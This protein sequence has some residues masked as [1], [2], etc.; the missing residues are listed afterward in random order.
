MTGTVAHGSVI[1]ITD[2]AARFGSRVNVK[3]LYVSLGNQKAGSPLGRRTDDYYNAGTEASAAHPVGALTQAY[4]YDFKGTET[5]NDVWGGELFFTENATNPLLQYVERYYDFDVYQA[6]YQGDFGFNLKT[7]RIWGD[8]R[9]SS[10]VCN[11]YVG[12]NGTWPAGETGA[13]NAEYTNDSA[14][15]MNTTVAAFQWL[16]EEYL[17]KNAS[18][19]NV[20]DGILEF[21]RD[22][23]LQNAAKTNFIT[24][25][26]ANPLPLTM[27]FLDQVSNGSGNGV[28][29]VY[30]YLGYMNFDDE[31]RRVYLSNSAT[32]APGSKLIP[33]I[34]TAWSPGA[35]NVQLVH[36]Q[37]VLSG[38]Y[39]HIRLGKNTWLEPVRLP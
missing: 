15:Y 7:N 16:S 36:S 32:R 28:A 2:A 26:T 30:E 29:H 25:T 18:A 9:L 24:H 23:T 19:P 22:N 34:Q 10:H 35:I 14:I 27:V 38:N 33:M 21:Y 20:A 8:W 37:L 17:F 5:A 13:I 12:Y 4:R 3:P 6:K 31:Y 39:L 11:I 1:T